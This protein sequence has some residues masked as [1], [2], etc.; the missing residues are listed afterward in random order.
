MSTIILNRPEVLNAMNSLMREELDAAITE[1]AR[2]ESVRALVITGQ[3]RGFCA[4]GDLKEIQALQGSVAAKEFVQKFNNMIRKLLYLEKPVITAV[5]GVAVGAGC[6]LAL[7]GDL[8]IA[9]EA[10]KFSEIFV[11]V[12]LIPD[13]GGTYLLAR[14]VG[15]VRAKKIIMSGEM[16]A[17][18]EA[19]N[20]G[21]ISMVVPDEK[22]ETVVAQEA[23]KL[24]A[25]PTKA[26]AFTK[27]VLNKNLDM[28]NALE[29]EA[30]INGLLIQSSDHKEATRAFFAKEDPKF[31]GC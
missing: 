30:L 16:I 24:A 28:E 20:I 12:G 2:D 29:Y 18:R 1:V 9:S 5:N 17:A 7:C 13:F 27:V 8:I 31:T 26:L 25:G 4:G 6:N 11:R 22:F 10:A 3:G 19:E 21:M 14:N 15:V 23:E